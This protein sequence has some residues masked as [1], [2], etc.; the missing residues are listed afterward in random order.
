MGRSVEENPRVVIEKSQNK[1]IG[2]AL[3]RRENPFTK[4]KAN[5]V[6]WHLFHKASH[7]DPQSRIAHL[8]C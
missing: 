6:Q 8:P 3:E 4:E 1:A 2:N 7:P 5:P